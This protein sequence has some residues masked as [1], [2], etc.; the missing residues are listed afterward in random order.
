MHEVALSMQMARIVAR[1]ADNRKVMAVRVEI[2]A[3]RQVV[4]ASLAHAWRFAVAGSNLADAE[5]EMIHRPAR[6]RCPAGHLTEPAPGFRCAECG[7]PGDVAQGL[8][9]RVIDI[10]IAGR[11]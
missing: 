5:L 11:S 1:A 6:V 7:A 2:G 8:E 9:F 10:E 3:L 4:P